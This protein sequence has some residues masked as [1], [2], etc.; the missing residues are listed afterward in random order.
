MHFTLQNQPYENFRLAFP[1]R[2]PTSWI[3]T[4]C[5]S[6]CTFFL[7]STIKS[8]SWTEPSLDPEIDLVQSLDCRLVNP[9][10]PKLYLKKSGFSPRLT[11]QTELRHCFSHPHAAQTLSMQVML[12]PAML[13]LYCFTKTSRGLILFQ[14]G[15]E[16]EYLETSFP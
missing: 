3:S 16:N 8:L 14:L 15:G 4:I 12:L 10:Q 11:H 1:R 2:M 5:D 6:M 13:P 7:S 9:N